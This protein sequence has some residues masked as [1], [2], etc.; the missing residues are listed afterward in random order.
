MICLAILVLITLQLRCWATTNT[1][2]SAQF[3]ASQVVLSC[4]NH[5]CQVALGSKEKSVQYHEI[6]SEFVLRLI[7]MLDGANRTCYPTPKGYSRWTPIDPTMHFRLHGEQDRF[8]YLGFYVYSDVKNL[9]LW[10]PRMYEKE[11]RL[12]CIPDKNQS[13]VGAI[14]REVE[15]FVKTNALP[16]VN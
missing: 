5:T 12:Y 7:A 4:S 6:P 8:N 1:T 13:C 11:H 10:N 15:M 3:L 2:D 16:P 9:F 14:L